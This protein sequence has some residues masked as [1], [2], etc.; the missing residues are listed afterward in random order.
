MD[1]SQ[2]HHPLYSPSSHEVYWRRWKSLKVDR[3]KASVQGGREL[4]HRLPPIPGFSGNNENPQSEELDSG[5]EADVEPE[6]EEE[7]LWELNSLVTSVNK[8]NDN[9]T[10]NDVSEWYINEV[11]DLA[12]FFVFAS[13]SVPSDTSTDVNDDPWSVIDALISLHA[14]VRLS[15]TA[16]QS[17]SDVKR[18]F[19]EVPAKR[20]C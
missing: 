4:L 17:V 13:D 16:Y 8:L 1:S 15:L 14:P 7:C 5:N 18:T 2:F 9:N 6:V 3:R 19:F 12:Y 11:L 20:K 10:A